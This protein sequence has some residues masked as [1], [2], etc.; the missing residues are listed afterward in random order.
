MPCSLR[1]SPFPHRDIRFTFLT[2]IMV[3]YHA[4][5]TELRFTP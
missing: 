3:K 5:K 4:K 2:V 1:L